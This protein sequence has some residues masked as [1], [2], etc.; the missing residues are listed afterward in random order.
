MHNV[1]A[2]TISVIA[3]AASTLGAQERRASTDFR[4]EGAIPDG[5]WL[6]V[7]NV[8][9]DITVSESTTGRVEV[10]GIKQWR[11]GDPDDVRIEVS[12]VGKNSEDVL[13]CALWGKTA[14]CDEDGYH[15]GKER[16]N[17]DNDVSVEFTVKLPKGVKIS[18]GTI[19]GGVEVSGASSEVEASTVNGAIEATSST[20]PVNASTVNGS[21]RARMSTL[22]GADNLDFSTVNGSIVVELPAQ[23]DAEVRMS[24]VN[25]RLTSR[26]YPL[27]LSGR[28]NPRSLRATIGKGGPRLSFT[29]VNGNVELRKRM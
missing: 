14:T 15:S 11:R 19:N 27:T 26:D 6:Q 8:N 16:R 7:R 10:I 22:A 17:R 24:T 12:K 5:R 13:I 4:W 1:F 25:G 29:T 3:L 2:S 9:G 20:G 28:I 18:V 21:I 23:L